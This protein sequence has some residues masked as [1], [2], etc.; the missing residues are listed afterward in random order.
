VNPRDSARTPRW[1]A[2][3]LGEFDLDPCS[4]PLSHVRAK[5]RLSLEAGDDGLAEGGYRTAGGVVPLS[6]DLRTFVN[7][8]YS[9]GSVLRW[10]EHYD[11]T[12]FCFLLRFD[13]RTRWFKRLV[14]L[15]RAI[16]VPHKIEFDPAPGIVF[17]SNIYPHALFFANHPVRL[18]P[19]GMGMLLFPTA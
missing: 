3:G 9:R 4:N 2:D 12:D 5:V 18:P 14:A 6:R 17:S 11:R 15:T 10:V 16:Y 7:P 1:L 13:P 8:P 19:P